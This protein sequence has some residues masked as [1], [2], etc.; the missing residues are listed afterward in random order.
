MNEDAL[1]Y[2]PGKEGTIL[3]MSLVSFGYYILI[4]N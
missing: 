2:L 1:I 3:S 4:V